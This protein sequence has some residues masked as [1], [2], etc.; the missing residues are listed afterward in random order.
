VQETLFDLEHIHQYETFHGPIKTNGVIQASN[1]KWCWTCGSWVDHT[2][3][4]IE[5]GSWRD[6]MNYADR[7]AEN[8]KWGIITRNDAIKL[9]RE[10]FQRTYGDSVTSID[11]AIGN[12]N[13]GVK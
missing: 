2:P 4:D 9:Y 7:M 11:I 8:I 10:E 6:R 1:S 5:L 12:L 3:E 13:E